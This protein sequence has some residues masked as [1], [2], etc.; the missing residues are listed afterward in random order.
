MT[1]QVSVSSY[2]VPFLLLLIWHSQRVKEVVTSVDNLLP[3]HFYHHIP[4]LIYLSYHRTS[5]NSHKLDHLKDNP[6]NLDHRNFFL[7][8]VERISSRY[9]VVEVRM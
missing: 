6:N 1:C 2:P 9:R 3:S 4:S 5:M 8:Q 7:L